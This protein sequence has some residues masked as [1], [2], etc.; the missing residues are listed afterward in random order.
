MN[1]DYYPDMKVTLLIL[2]T[3]LSQVIRILCIT[4]DPEMKNQ[5]LEY[6]YPIFLLKKKKSDSTSC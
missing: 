1:D 2:C 5:S 4:Y 6:H 3:A